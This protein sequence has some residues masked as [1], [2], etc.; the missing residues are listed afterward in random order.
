MPAVRAM[1]EELEA[2]VEERDL[3]TTRKTLQRLFA[4]LEARLSAE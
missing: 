2:G 3:Q 1:V 4:N